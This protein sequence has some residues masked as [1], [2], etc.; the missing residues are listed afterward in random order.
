M[1]GTV[2]C[3]VVSKTAQNTGIKVL[4][5]TLAIISCTEICAKLKSAEKAALKSAL[6]MLD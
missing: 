2:F 4:N 6:L 3:K 1:Q 5:F